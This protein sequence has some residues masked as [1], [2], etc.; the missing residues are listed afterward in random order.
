MNATGTAAFKA[1][2]LELVI[3]GASF[4]GTV[5]LAEAISMLR[6]G[7]G[8]HQCQFFGVLD[9]TSLYVLFCE[10]LFEIHSLP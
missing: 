2:E 5:E 10:S 7:L 8:C 4:L 3:S 9:F 6:N 1:V